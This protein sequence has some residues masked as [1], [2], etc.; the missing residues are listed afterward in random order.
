MAT[1]EQLKSEV[2]KLKRDAQVKS[3]HN[4]EMKRIEL[5]RKKLKKEIKTLK[6]PKRE[7][8]KKFILQTKKGVGKMVQ[9]LAEQR[10]LQREKELMI[11]KKK[12]ELIAKQ[13]KRQSLKKRSPVKRRSPVRRS[14]V[15]RSPV[16]RRSPAFYSVSDYVDSLSI[17]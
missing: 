16:K 8:A 4:M 6:N 17:K 13:K 11:E 12:K 15:R 7:Q 5:E 3:E 9:A 10:R 14:P 1:L 2:S